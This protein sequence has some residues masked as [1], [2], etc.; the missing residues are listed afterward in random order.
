MSF[1][2]AEALETYGRLP[3]V[4]CSALLHSVLR[5]H[6][7]LFPPCIDL[8]RTATL[9]DV[10]ARSGEWVREVAGTYPESVVL[11]LARS[12]VWVE[13]ARM[14]ARQAKVDNV[15]FW[16]SP[17]T[18]LLAPSHSFDLVRACC[19]W[20]DVSPQAWPTVLHEWVRVCSYGG[21]IVWIEPNLPVTNSAVS[22]SVCELLQR[23]IALS[24]HPLS[25]T[26]EMERLLSAA[27][28]HGVQ[29]WETSIDLSYGTNASTMLC[30]HLPLLLSIVQRFLRQ[31][32]VASAKELRDLSK[33][34]TADVAATTFTGC[35]SLTTVVGEKRFPPEEEAL[36]E[37]A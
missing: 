25:I 35:W 30:E 15:S 5:D 3:G 19:V 23:A 10:A 9:L 20:L 1:L 32:K 11:G 6:M 28:G 27:L 37:R 34:I 29:V 4:R 16:E 12:N 36:A 14:L 17:L 21:H 7:G 33:Q 22:A 13:Y 18:E 8:A 24:G 31:M 26:Q 2:S